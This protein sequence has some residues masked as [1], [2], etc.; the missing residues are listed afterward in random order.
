MEWQFENSLER[1][2]ELDFESSPGYVIER[3][4][5]SEKET[6]NESG[7]IITSYDS[8]MRFLSVKEYAKYIN[9]IKTRQ[10][11]TE[12]TVMFLMDLTLIGGM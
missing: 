4:N 3:R 10:E 9:S 5:I 11:E 2:V 7:E 6:E 8:E 12:A 1:P